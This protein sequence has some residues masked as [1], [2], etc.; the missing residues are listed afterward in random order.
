M[1]STIQK[2]QRQPFFRKRQLKKQF[3]PLGTRES[4]LREGIVRRVGGRPAA[5]LKAI[6]DADFALIAGP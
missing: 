1:N 2:L 4:F 5:E 3:G 6:V